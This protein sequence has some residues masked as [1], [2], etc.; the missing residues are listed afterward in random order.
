MSLHL[1]I[2]IGSGQNL[3]G[4]KS[5]EGSCCFFYFWNQ[6][7]QQS[8]LKSYLGGG[9]L[10]FSFSPR[11]LGKWSNLTGAYFS[12]VLVQP[13]TRYN[14]DTSCPGSCISHFL[15]RKIP[16]VLNSCGVLHWEI[17]TE[18]EL[19]RV[20]FLLVLSD[21]FRAENVTSIWGIK[22]SLGRSCYI[23]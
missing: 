23:F 9:F 2:S 22:R 1:Y 14:V 11:K 16:V 17:L 4:V 3:V 6:G 12:D 21:L 7:V 19:F 5:C 10:Y 15:I 20:T 18:P 8:M 13:P